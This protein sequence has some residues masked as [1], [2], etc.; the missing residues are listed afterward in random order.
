ML[1]T[2]SAGFSRSLPYST[3][4]LAVYSFTDTLYRSISVESLN[5]SSALATSPRTTPSLVL[6]SA[7]TLLLSLVQLSMLASCSPSALP[8]SRP[9]SFTPVV[10][11]TSLVVSTTALLPSE[12]RRR[13]QLSLAACLLVESGTG[14][15]P[16]V[17]G[18]MVVLVVASPTLVRVLL[19]RPLT[20]L[21]VVPA[22]GL[23]L[24]RRRKDTSAMLSRFL[25]VCAVLPYGCCSQHG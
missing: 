11:S 23:L 19:L 5:T 24:L 14:L 8:T 9:S 22:D 2:S 7:I 18:V 1:L 17:C 16:T 3:P 21:L 13:S 4:L 12:V 6:V 25:V 15:A 20:V 10:L